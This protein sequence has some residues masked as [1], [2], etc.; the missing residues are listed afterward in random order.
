MHR[1]LEGWG[2][3]QRFIDCWYA[4]LERQS[5]IADLPCSAKKC[6]GVGCAREGVTH[7]ARRGRSVFVGG[8][9]FSVRAEVSTVSPFAVRR[10]AVAIVNVQEWLYPRD[11]R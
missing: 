1:V 5:L 9:V 6:D 11:A 10:R 8:A 7:G 3:W 4:T 2:A